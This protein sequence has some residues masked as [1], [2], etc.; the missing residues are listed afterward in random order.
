MKK[1][2]IRIAALAGILLLV[3]LVCRLGTQSV[4]VAGVPA[5][6]PGIR[7]E[8]IRF[9]GE[10]P[11]IVEPGVPEVLEGWVRIPVRPRGPGETLVDLDDSAG[12]DLAELR[13]RVS[14]F[15]TIYDRTTGG[16]TGDSVVMVAFTVFCFAVALIMLW[17]YRGLK[18]PA[19]YSYNTIY[20]AGFSLFSLMTGITMLEATVRHLSRP[21]DYNMLTAYAEISGAGWRFVMATAPLLTAFAA[22][23][24][25]SNAA[26]LRHE[27]FHPKNVLGIGAALVLVAGEA[28]AFCLYRH[29][30]LEPEWGGRLRDTVCNAYSTA[31]AY[32]ECMLAGTMICGLKAARSVPEGLADCILILGCWFRKDGSLTPLLRGRVDRAVQVW[33]EQKAATGREALLIPS[34]GKGKDEPMPEAEAMRRYLLQRGIPEEKIVPEDRSRSTYE[35]MVFS[36]ALIEREKPDARVIYATTNYHVFRSG[37]LAARAGLSA[38]GVGSST[39]WWYWPNAFLRE[40]AGLFVH[41]IPQELALLAV[42]LAFFGA[43]SAALG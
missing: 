40:C 38:E 22:A 37:V 35:N 29:G 33:S 24:A 27:R 2:R 26:L 12:N 19:F 13:L 6:A 36:K 16:F 8:G 25:V 7:P 23:L 18:G 30:L 34:G 21:Y 10:I 14:R 20:A 43:L 1:A 11:G 15:G 31:F 39:K 5:A 17:V 32:F 42:T 4:Y 41:R 9:S 3:C 28:L